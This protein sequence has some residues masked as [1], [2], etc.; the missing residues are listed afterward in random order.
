MWTVLSS[1]FSIK[2][3]VDAKLEKLAKDRIVNRTWAEVLNVN[4]IHCLFLFHWC[5][6][7]KW[8]F[9]AGVQLL[10]QEQKGHSFYFIS[11]I[12]CLTF[13]NGVAAMAPPWTSSLKLRNRSPRHLHCYRNRKASKDLG[14]TKHCVP[15]RHFA[16]GCTWKLQTQSISIINVSI[17]LRLWDFDIYM[18]LEIPNVSP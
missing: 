6:L 5:N 1:L 11:I 17:S 18:D 12:C 7:S 16:L 14:A 2:I 10:Q 13:S 9:H 15:R 8:S 4:I 3:S